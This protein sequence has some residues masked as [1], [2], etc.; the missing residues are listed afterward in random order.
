M[1]DGSVDPLIV[2]FSA[3]KLLKLVVEEGNQHVTIVNYFIVLSFY[4]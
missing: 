2:V 4:I 3:M 1:F